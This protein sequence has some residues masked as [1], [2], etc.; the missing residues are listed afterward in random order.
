[1]L[2][3]VGETPI[4]L[5]FSLFGVPVRVHPLFWLAGVLLGSNILSDPDIPGGRMR[6]AALL[7]WLAC[8]FTSILVHEMGHAL[9][10]K[11]F[12]WPP[13]VVLY[14]FGGLA[15][16]RPTRGYTTSRSILISFAGP[17]AGF[18]LFGLVVVFGIAVM[19]ND[20]QVHLLVD[21]AFWQLIAINLVWGLVNLVPVLPL[22]GGRICEALCVH[23][24]QYDGNLWAL[25]I[26]IGAAAVVAIGF[27][28]LH[29]LIG[30]GLFAPIMFG[31][32]AFSNFQAYQ[33]YRHGPW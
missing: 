3:P 33:A 10:A 19:L 13:E 15:T 4:D 1:M 31:L 22:D 7:V 21:F 27:L 2:G 23:F 8:L 25:R 14:H 12:G 32:L 11:W 6:L 26:S 24:R 5:R 9:F 20:L 17:A 16:Y 18:V 28:A 30:T 29:Q